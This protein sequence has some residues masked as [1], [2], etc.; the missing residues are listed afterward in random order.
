M[1]FRKE[2]LALN[3]TADSKG[4][5]LLSEAAATLIEKLSGNREHGNPH[6][7][8]LPSPAHAGIAIPAQVS[9]VAEILKAPGYADQLAA[10]LLVAAKFLS[11]G[12]LYKHIRVQGGAYGGMCQYDPLSGLFAFLSY[13]DPH[14]VETLKVYGDT[15][16]FLAKEKVKGNYRR[17]WRSRQAHG[18]PDKR[19]LG[20]DSGF[21]RS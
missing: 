5:S 19:L 13:R 2:R 9:Y 16:A 17:H 8:P 21:Y 14:I 12:F 6:E 4:L 11:N 18:P 7:T 10:S 20:H 3:M 1:I 15:P